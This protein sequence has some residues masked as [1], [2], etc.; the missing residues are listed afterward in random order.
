MSS[1]DAAGTATWV[2]AACRAR[3]WPSARS[4]LSDLE[5]SL[6]PIG[7]WDRDGRDVGFRKMWGPAPSITGSHS[8]FLWQI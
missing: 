7:G 3:W 1:V 2:E 4:P 8:Q 6:A 5:T